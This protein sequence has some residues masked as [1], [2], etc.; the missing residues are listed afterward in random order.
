M[1]TEYHYH[2]DMPLPSNR[3]VGLVFAVVFLVIG[4]LPLAGGGVVHYWALATGTGF[5]VMALLFPSLLTPLNRA[6]MA[7]GMMLHRVVSPLALGI[8]FFGVITPTAIF[9]RLTGK[10]PLR[11]RFDRE[12]ST[13]WI[14]REATDQTP[15]RLKDQF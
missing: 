8:I 15:E 3:V 6:W 11:L 12:A 9:V 4:V 14:A 5:A 7:F 10:S 2:D 13:Y 1:D